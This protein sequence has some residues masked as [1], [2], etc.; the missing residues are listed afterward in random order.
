MDFTAV[1][2][3]MFDGMGLRKERIRIVAPVRTFHAYHQAHRSTR[4]FVQFGVG[5]CLSLVSFSFRSLIPKS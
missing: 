5:S 1:D 2:S 4:A 3:D